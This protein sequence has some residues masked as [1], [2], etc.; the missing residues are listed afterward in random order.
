M[1]FRHCALLTALFA[2]QAT[3]CLSVPL[4]PTESTS[5]DD[6]SS[7]F[8]PSS[9]SVPSEGSRESS[10]RIDPERPCQDDDTR[11]M[12]QRSLHHYG[13]FERAT[14]AEVYDTDPPSSSGPY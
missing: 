11:G 7:G 14:Q 8:T 12:C 13:E 9:E 1:G 4:S 2:L 3:G 5:T 6:L 10:E